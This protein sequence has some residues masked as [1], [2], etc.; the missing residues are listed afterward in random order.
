MSDKRKQTDDVL[1]FNYCLDQDLRDQLSRF[2]IELHTDSG[3]VHSISLHVWF[4]EHRMQAGELIRRLN[5]LKR[6][7]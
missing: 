3:P 2:L 1:Q 7:K 5:K 4:K 6:V